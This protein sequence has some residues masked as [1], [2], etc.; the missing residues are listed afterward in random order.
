MTDKTDFPQFAEP[1][2]KEQT[3]PFAVL[4]ELRAE[5]VLRDSKQ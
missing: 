5:N 3:L 4:P 1:L 2:P